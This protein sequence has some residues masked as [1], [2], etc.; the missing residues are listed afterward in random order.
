MPENDNI[1]PPA[2]QLLQYILIRRSFHPVIA[3]HKSEVFPSGQAHSRIACRRNAGIFLM[4]G[5]NSLI[6]AAYS[7]NR[8]PLPSVLPSSTPMI[9]ILRRVCP[10][11]LS[12]HSPRYGSTLYIGTITEIAGSPAICSAVFICNLLMKK[13]FVFSHQKAG[14]N[15]AAEIAI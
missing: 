7:S 6:F 12:R 13:W 1:R 8:A 10:H 4:H 3:V 11:R 9:S 5:D 15:F 2:L 14:D